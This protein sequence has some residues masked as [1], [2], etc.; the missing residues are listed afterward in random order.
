MSPGFAGRQVPVDRLQRMGA[1]ACDHERGRAEGFRA[2]FWKDSGSAAFV[3]ARLLGKDLAMVG[4][5]PMRSMRCAPKQ[6]KFGAPMAKLRHS[7]IAE[8]AA[9]KQAA[10]IRG[11]I[12]DLGRTIHIL[13]I[14]ILTEEESVRVFD[15]SDPAYSILARTLTARRD[16]LIVTVADIEERLRAIT[17]AIP[18]ALSEAA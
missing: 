4:Q 15:R 2:V 6:T 3:V 7:G 13:N 18:A 16:N 14:D 1:S 17:A 5:S 9:L 12:Y 8:E 11:T 10:V